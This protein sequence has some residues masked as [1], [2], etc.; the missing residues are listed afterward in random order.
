MWRRLLAEAIGTFLFTLSISVSHFSVFN[1]PGTYY[2]A[3]TVAGSVVMLMMMTGFISGSHL[4][5][6]ITLGCITK[7]ILSAKV[8]K[9]DLIEYI[10]YIIIQMIS[11]IPAGYLAWAMNRSSMYFDMPIDSSKANAFFAELVYSTLIVGVALMIG[12][13]N[14]S[15]VI[16]TLG[17]GSAY[18]GGILAV[19]LISGGCFNPA[20]GLAVNLTHYTAHGTHMEH[21]WI[22]LVAPM[23][24]GALGGV[25][26][27]LF[28]SELNAQK[29]SKI[30]PE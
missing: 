20:V 28:L 15:I 26:N 13:L 7:H 21:L 6:A 25:F 5:P 17:L 1:I 23:L 30:E 24:G 8:S 29:K 2:S 3:Y 4:N 19:G 14:D 9:Q 10:L 12:Q 18:F 27:T 16:G 11:A 22:Y